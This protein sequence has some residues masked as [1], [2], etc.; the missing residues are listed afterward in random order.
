MVGEE[1]R[2]R[3]RVLEWVRV[4]Q[5]SS[6]AGAN[7]PELQDGV[8]GLWGRVERRR[9]SK[10][11]KD[12]GHIEWKPRWARVRRRARVLEVH[13]MRLLGRTRSSATENAP[14]F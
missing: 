10:T 13:S 14:C 4:S 5:D 9:A 2:V 8:D 6:L 7:R 11:P 3:K 1:E 12:P